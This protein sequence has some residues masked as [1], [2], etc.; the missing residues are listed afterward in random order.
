MVSQN[1]KHS[2]VCGFDTWHKRFHV[3]ETNEF[4]VIHQSGISSAKGHSIAN[5]RLYDCLQDS[6][7]L[8]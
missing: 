1:E 7:L 2:C 5:D 6:G 8:D 4:Y 3:N